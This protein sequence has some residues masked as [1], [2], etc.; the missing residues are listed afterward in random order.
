[1]TVG[2]RPEDDCAGPAKALKKRTKITL[3]AETLVTAG[4]SS[5]VSPAG[6]SAV[7]ATQT[8]PAPTLPEHRPYRHPEG[9]AHFPLPP[10][11][12]AISGRPP[13]DAEVPAR[14]SMGMCRSFPGT[15]SA[16]ISH[17][18]A[19]ERQE[20]SVGG[21]QNNTCVP[22]ERARER[23]EPRSSTTGGATLT[24]D[25][26]RVLSKRLPPS[27]PQPGAP[28]RTS[29]RPDSRLAL[30]EGR[31]VGRHHADAADRVPELDGRAA[32]FRAP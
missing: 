17:N 25:D 29:Q 26:S 12:G 21:E 19:Q 15:G 24:R 32:E 5:T 9:F 22:G 11:P 8:V 31:H 30:E 1:M 3:V 13:R 18:I 14:V 23:A 6:V 4:L 10:R 20:Q 16:R 28:E 2:A 27:R 7:S